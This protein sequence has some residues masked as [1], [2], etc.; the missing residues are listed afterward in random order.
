MGSGCGRGRKAGI[1]QQAVEECGL[2]VVVLKGADVGVELHALEVVVHDEVDDT[3]N[4]VGAVGGRG[5][6][7][8]HFDP[9]HQRGWNVVHVGGA[10]AVDRRIA[11]HQPA[12]VD[13]HQRAL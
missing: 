4:R 13:Q 9:L 11:R 1:L 5:A 8:E 12:P 2:L 3:G 6:A 7:R 10:V